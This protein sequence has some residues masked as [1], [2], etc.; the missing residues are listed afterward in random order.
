VSVIVG[1]VAMQLAV[2]F[3]DAL[4]SVSGAGE[5][6][7]VPS[8]VALTLGTGLVSGAVTAVLMLARRRVA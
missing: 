7:Y 2:A 6:T 5:L 8:L 1:C 4:W 3:R